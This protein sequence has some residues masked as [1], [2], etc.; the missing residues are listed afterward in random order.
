MRRVRLH[1]L[2]MDIVTPRLRLRPARAEDLAAVHAVL[3]HP[4]ATRWWSTPPHESPETTAVWLDSMIAGNDSGLDLL[5]ER[6]GVVIGKAGFWSPPDIGYILHPDH[7]GQGLATEAITAVLDRMFA[8]TE[9]DEAVADVDPENAPSL[10]L[11]EKLGFRR[12]GFEAATVNVG[13]VW[14]DS[15]YLSLS[16]TDWA[17]R[18]EA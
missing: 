5:I 4:E 13:G 14:K 8:L 17:R 12:T 11:L 18:S 16:R 3:S 10:R 15:V 1:S 7:W 2:I 9:F 6:G